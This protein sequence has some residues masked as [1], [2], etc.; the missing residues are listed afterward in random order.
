MMWQNTLSCFMKWN[1]IHVLYFPCIL[2]LSLRKYIDFIP[3]NE[4]MSKNIY[5]QTWELGLESCEGSLG[6]KHCSRLMP[7]IT[8]GTFCLGLNLFPKIT[9]TN[10]FSFTTNTSNSNTVLYYTNDYFDAMY[11]KLFFFF[12]TWICIGSDRTKCAIFEC[13]FNNTFNSTIKAE[14]TSAL[15][16]ELNPCR[17]WN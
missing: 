14:V 9:N 15:S 13:F 4:V 12:F 8:K 2:Y 11:W 3:W 1:V 7:I 17:C 6:R 16:F 10:M 5:F